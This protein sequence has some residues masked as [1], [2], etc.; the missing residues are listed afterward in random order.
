MACRLER[1]LPRVSDKAS[2]KP[3]N[4]KKDQERVLARESRVQ[5]NAGRAIGNVKCHERSGKVQAGK[6]F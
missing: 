4:W 6:G 3:T 2:D 5:G 1:T